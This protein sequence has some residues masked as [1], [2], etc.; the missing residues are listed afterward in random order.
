MSDTEAEQL[1]KSFRM[2]TEEMYDLKLI[3]PTTAEKRLKEHPK[4]W[5]KVIPLIT[6]SDGALSVA[7]ESD[8]RPAVTVEAAGVGLNESYEDLL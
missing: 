4:R 5:H 6:Q 3:S 7:S 2:T 8:K 1:F